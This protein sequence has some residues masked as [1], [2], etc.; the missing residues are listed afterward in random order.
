MGPIQ[1]EQS[2]RMPRLGAT[3]ATMRDTITVQVPPKA[4]GRWPYFV[5]RPPTT[6]IDP[7][8]AAVRMLFGTVVAAREECIATSLSI[9]TSTFDY[10]RGLRL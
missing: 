8:R 9:S 7:V 6:M 10:A 4:T 1:D 3:L 5:T 2:L